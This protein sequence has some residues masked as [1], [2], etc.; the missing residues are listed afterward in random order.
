MF[1]CSKI[2]RPVTVWRDWL[3]DEVLGRYNLSERK[4]SA[5][6]YLKVQGT[7]TNSQYQEKFAVAK[8][9]ASLDLN[10]L[11]TQGLLQREGKTGKGVFYRLAKGASKGQKGHSSWNETFIGHIGHF[12]VDR[13]KN[14][15]SL[16]ASNA[17]KMMQ[18]NRR[19]KPRQ[20]CHTGVRKWFINGSSGL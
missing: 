10:E 11:V 19:I 18:M 16:N 14:L 8:R 1:S 9:T 13:L 6:Q 12:S 4:R 15:M 7:I 17:L 20:T 3:T 5:I 2:F